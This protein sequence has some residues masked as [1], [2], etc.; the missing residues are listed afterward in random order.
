[1]ITLFVCIA[2][3]LSAPEAQAEYDDYGYGDYDHPGEYS[4]QRYN[5]MEHRWETTR[6]KKQLKY[7]G[8]E[9]EWSYEDPGAQPEYN[10]MENRWEYQK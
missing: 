4:K 10:P 2:I 8:N 5:P 6:G 7:N 3:L 9:N 1:M